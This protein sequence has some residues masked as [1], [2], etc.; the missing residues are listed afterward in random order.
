MSASFLAA[1]GLAASMVASDSNEAVADIA[2]R[3]IARTL[4]E[5][6]LFGYLNHRDAAVRRCAALALGRIQDRAATRYLAAVLEDPDLEVAR[7]A[8]FA[9]GQIGDPES[10]EA[11]TAKAHGADSQGRALAVEALGRIGGKVVEVLV[12]ALKDPD[13]RVRGEAALAL[14]RANAS[15]DACGE[16][17][18][19]AIGDDDPGVRWRA[20]YALMRLKIRP[21]ALRDAASDTDALARGFACRGLGDV[22]HSPENEVTLAVRAIDGEWTVA[23]EAAKSLAKTTTG[24]FATARALES[25]MTAPSF[26]VR[27]EAA[28]AAASA[29]AKRDDAPL[30][31]ALRHVAESDPSR[32]V[33]A[34][35]L[36]ALVRCEPDDA[37]KA[38]CD[39][40][41]L[42]ADAWAR[43]RVADALAERKPGWAVPALVAMAHE[44]DLQVREQALTALGGYP[45]SPE[46]KA[47]LLEAG[48]VC[49]LGIRGTAVDTLGGWKSP[50]LAASFLGWLAD[51]P[52]SDLAEVRANCL[53]ALS[54]T[55]GAKLVPRLESALADPD[56]IVRSRAQTLLRESTGCEYR[57]THVTKGSLPSVPATAGAPRVRFE[58]DKG[59]FTIETFPSEAPVRVARLVADVERR[60]Y[61]GLTIHRVVSN[62]VV[63]GGDPRGDGWG[64]GTGVVE[65]IGRRHFERGSV[66][67]PTS[68]KDTGGSQFFVTHGPTPHLDGRYTI[69]ARVVEGMEVV[70]LLEPKDRILRAGL[71]R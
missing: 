59:S 4:G 2:S 65:E 22:P 17:L 3:E 61:D 1:L 5:G 50:D 64:G 45:T 35:A 38:L 19:A 37:A 7:E 28:L 9:L 41:K 55:E 69:F 49:D 24:E 52:G 42:P 27:R 60:F 18:A 44:S 20:A 6:E 68:G 46:A 34:D 12:S 40:G 15:D 13:A 47:A 29:L 63:Q 58:T 31:A 39:L 25:A 51:S 71:I 33:R 21:A 57:L 54:K 67:T 14:W 8:A 66:G 16:A 30:R 23:V 48:G 32:A 70:D 62:F 26:H 36:H 10:A 56:V 53:D 11:V 43:A